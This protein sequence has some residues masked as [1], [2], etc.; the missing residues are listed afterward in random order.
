MNETDAA[1][2]RV[3]LLSSTASRVSISQR[4]RYDGQQ[5]IVITSQVFLTSAVIGYAES[6]LLLRRRFARYLEA[7]R[8]APYHQLLHY[9][10]C[11]FSELSGETKAAG[12]NSDAKACMACRLSMI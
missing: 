9:N 11:V 1:S 6:P 2:S 8:A 5:L 10:R 12:M 3:S 4:I 7:A